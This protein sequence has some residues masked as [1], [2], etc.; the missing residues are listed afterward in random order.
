MLLFI[1]RHGDPIYNPDSL[2]EKGHAQARALVRRFS[3][4]GLDRIYA[5]PM[6]RAQQTAAPT[7]EALGLPVAIEEWTSE[8][9]AWK[10][11]APVNPETG[12]AKWYFRRDPGTVKPE[13][14]D[15]DPEDE[16][17]RR[18]LARIRAASDE[19]LA[20]HGYVREGHLYRIER[21]NEERIAVFC[22]EGFGLTWLSHLLG[23]S[24]MHFWA[25]HSITH[26]GVMAIRFKNYPS[27]Y[28]C[29]D[30]LCH[31]DMSHILCDGELPFE[32]NNSIPM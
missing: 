9:L 6:I 27:G 5:S 1:I 14:Y 22:H 13:D 31:S 19:F 8:S 23:V 24:P 18:G 21:A 15:K 10:D 2:T 17:I 26:S 16:S 3:V 4:H 11:L 29:P 28:T 32:Y 20:R 7:A 12:R 25:T 30:V